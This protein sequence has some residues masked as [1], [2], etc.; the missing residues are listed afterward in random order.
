MPPVRVPILTV[1]PTRESPLLKLRTFSFPLKRFQSLIDNAPV[2]VLFAILIPNI[3]LLLLYVRG[4]FAESDVS[5]IFVATTPLKLNRFLER[6]LRLPDNVLKFVV[7]LN[8]FP[9]NVLKFVERPETVPDR[10]L[11]FPER[12]FTVPERLT[13]LPE[14]LA[15]FPVAVKR[16]VL[17]AVILPERAF[18]ART[19]VK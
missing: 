6:V 1:F 4:P 19:S 8:R 16:F 15:I 2:V 10:E 9:D 13:R 18:C 3:P 5:Q 12:R 14:R 11:K 17:I 7:R